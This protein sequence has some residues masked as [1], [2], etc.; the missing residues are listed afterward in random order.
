MSVNLWVCLSDCLLVCS[1][2]GLSVRL[3]A[4]LFICWFVCLIVCMSVHLVRVA[5]R[6]IYFLKPVGAFSHII[7]GGLLYVHTIS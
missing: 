6:L 1:A 5:D 2:V 7:D 3:F 4:C